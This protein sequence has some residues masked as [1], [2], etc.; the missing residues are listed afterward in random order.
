MGLLPDLVTRPAARI[1]AAAQNALE[2]AR[3]GGL[4]TGEE[5]APYE[6]AA[7][8]A[9]HRLRRYFPDAASGPAIVLVPPMMLAAD[10]YDVTP[11]S[12]AVSVLHEHGADPWVVD[13]GAP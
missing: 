13:F 11:S 2:V 1:G 8:G 4:E 5:A 10:V 3:F 12:S 7:R 6:V 9:I